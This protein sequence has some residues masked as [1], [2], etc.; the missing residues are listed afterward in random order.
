MNALIIVTAA[1][2]GPISSDIEPVVATV[3]SSHVTQVAPAAFDIPTSVL[4]LGAGDSLGCQMFAM[5]LVVRNEV[6]ST[7]IAS[8]E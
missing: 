4:A 6:A 7:S 8:A 3:V 2:T 5:E 1:L